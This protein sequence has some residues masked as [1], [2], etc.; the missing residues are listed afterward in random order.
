MQFFSW[1][2]FFSN[3]PKLL[4]TLPVTL[5]VVVVAY[6]L[7]L[8]LAVLI[9]CLRIRK[10][11]VLNQLA[12]IF[13]SFERD[14][15]LLV[16]MLVSYYG[17]PL[18]LSSLLD[19]STRGWPRIIFVYIAYT[20]NVAA[21]LSEVFRSAI[22]SIPQ[23]QKDAALACG[24]TGRQCFLRII[25]PQSIRIALPNMWTFLISLVKSTS[26][27][28][29]IGVVDII[30]RAQAIG[31]ATSHSLESYIIVALVFVTLSLLLQLPYGFVEKKLS[32]YTRQ[33]EEKHDL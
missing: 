6:S 32:F 26:Y 33:K 29:M 8:V 9:A 20:A 25:L 2:R 10:I 1:S 24:L 3:L 15:P 11:P 27:V 13:I 4:K 14:T 17:I 28:Y 19:I 7:G 12:V 23:G 31:S 16:Q 21:F 5:E 18:L 22:L 30:G